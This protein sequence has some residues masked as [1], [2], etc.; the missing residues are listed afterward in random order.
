[1]IRQII[2]SACL[3]VAASSAAFAQA[4]G[5][6]IDLSLVVT[7][8]A[9]K[10]LSTFRKVEVKLTSPS[11]EKRKAIAPRGYDVEAKDVNKKPTEPKSP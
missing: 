11:G 4:S 6:R 9:N 3:I 7:D 1:M 10:A 2:C 8:K 5:P